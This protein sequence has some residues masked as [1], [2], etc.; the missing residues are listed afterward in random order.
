MKKV[1]HN[2]KFF[3]INNELFYYENS[4]IIKKQVGEDKKL[5]SYKW[6]IPMY[7]YSINKVW[8]GE[9]RF[10][11][12][13]VDFSDKK[14]KNDNWRWKREYKYSE[15]GKD[16]WNTEEEAWKAYNKRYSEEDKK[17]YQELR[18]LRFT[19]ELKPEL[20]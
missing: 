16:C 2:Q 5:M 8:N 19:Q 3:V 7:V 12:S 17:V 20:I 14:N 1:N 13:P 18:R 15:I 11:L 4:D 9:E 6:V 10:E